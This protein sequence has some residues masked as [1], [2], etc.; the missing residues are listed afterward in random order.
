MADIANEIAAIQVATSGSTIRTALVDALEKINIE[1][2][3]VADDT[4]TEGSTNLVTSNGIYES[5][6]DISAEVNIGSITLSTTWLGDGPY[7]QV[8]EIT[9]ATI[10]EA[11]KIDLQP[12][13]TVFQQLISDN[14]VALWA[15]NDDGV[16]TIYALG[17]HP[18]TQL[19][20]QCSVTDTTV[21]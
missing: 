17:A 4:P 19:T 18:T 10:T 8:A 15:Q 3:W 1:Q 21:D 12:D 11:S 14:V 7:Y 20:I 16:C 13:N 6:E 9:G 5:L 2:S